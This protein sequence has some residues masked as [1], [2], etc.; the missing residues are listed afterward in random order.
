MTGY[1]LFTTMSRPDLG[2]SQPPIEWV[3]GDLTTGVKLPVHEAR[4]SPPS[5]AADKNETVFN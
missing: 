3:L 5:S 2:P 1:F 4:H